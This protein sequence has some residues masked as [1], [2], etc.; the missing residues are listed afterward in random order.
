MA[1][2][3]PSILRRPPFTPSTKTRKRPGCGQ[4]ASLYDA[5]KEA[6]AAVLEEGKA[7]AFPPGPGDKAGADGKSHP[8]AK[9]RSIGKR[10][11][12]RHLPQKA[13]S[14]RTQL[15]RPNGPRIYRRE[16]A[17]GEADEKGG[18]V[19]GQP[20]DNRQ[21]KPQVNRRESQIQEGP[22]T[23]LAPQGTLDSHPIHPL[24]P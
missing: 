9:P 8:A 18:G 20:G 16:A 14:S 10:C 4:G 12:H 15:F 7:P 6:A 3:Y 5:V 24:P 11:G 19:N 21:S 1:A 17:A 23:D 22:D 2:A 13:V